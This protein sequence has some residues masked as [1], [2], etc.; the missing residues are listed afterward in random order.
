MLFRSEL[1]T[2][3]VPG[4]VPGIGGTR[5]W[6]LFAWPAVPGEAGMASEK[7]DDSDCLNEVGLSSRLGRDGGNFGASPVGVL[8][9]LNP[10]CD[11]SSSDAEP[12]LGD[13]GPN[14]GGIGRAA[15]VSV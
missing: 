11:I 7:Y 6:R 3:V 13:I 10:A 1:A 5:L 4:V 14:G 9:V 8:I 12:A 2:G 15:C